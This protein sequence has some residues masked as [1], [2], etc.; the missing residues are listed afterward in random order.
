MTPA[1]TV[2]GCKVNVREVLCSAG[3]NRI[4]CVADREMPRLA[5]TD[6]VP[7]LTLTS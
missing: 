6:H 5:E 7:D 2:I 3:R 4:P 1:V